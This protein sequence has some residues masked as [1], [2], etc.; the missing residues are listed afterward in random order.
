MTGHF[1]DVGSCTVDLCV[2]MNR[3]LQFQSI[4]HISI[5][6][7]GFDWKHVN[8]TDPKLRIPNISFRPIRNLREDIFRG[9]FFIQK[10]STRHP[11]LKFFSFPTWSSMD[12]ACIKRPTCQKKQ[13]KQLNHQTKWPCQHT[14]RKNRWM[15]R[16]A[17][18][19]NMSYMNSAFVYLKINKI[20]KPS[21][22]PLGL[23]LFYYY[24]FVPLGLVKLGIT[25]ST[26]GV[27]RGRPSPACTSSTADEAM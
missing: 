11:A 10:H 27:R 2:Y 7:A 20:T 14:R 19:P 16:A 21:A 1:G 22:I 4:F 17:C 26:Q 23:V 6:I 24:G 12:M 18:W 25:F 13:N 9:L 8:A 15:T 3:H 5:T